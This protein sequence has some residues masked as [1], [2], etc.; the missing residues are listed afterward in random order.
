MRLIRIAIRRRVKPFA[1][2]HSIMPLRKIAKKAK[3]H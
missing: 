2:R 1:R 3:G